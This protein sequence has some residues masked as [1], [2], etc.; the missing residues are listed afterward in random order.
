MAKKSIS[1]LCSMTGL[2]KAGFDVVLEELER[3]NRIV[4]RHGSVML[5]V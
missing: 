5:N 3:E 4:M 1:R 2:K